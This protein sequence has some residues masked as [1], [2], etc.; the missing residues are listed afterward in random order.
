MH[1][2]RRGPVGRGTVRAAQSQHGLGHRLPVGAAERFFATGFALE[3]MRQNFDD[4]ERVVTE[5]GP[6]VEES[7][8]A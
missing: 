6:A 7:G 1:G 3:Q 4:L 2:I 5:W 8:P